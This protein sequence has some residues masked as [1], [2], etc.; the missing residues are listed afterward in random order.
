MKK[1]LALLFSILLL[2]S[3]PVFADSIFDLQIEGISIGDSL[4][5]YMSE[6]EIINSKKIIYDDDEFYDLIAKPKILEIYDYLVFGVK[7]EDNRFLIYSINALLVYDNDIKS[8]LNKK[9]EI[10]SNIEEIFSEFTTVKEYQRPHDEDKTGKSIFYST[11]FNFKSGANVRVM[12]LDLT[13]EF[14]KGPDHLRVIIN[15][16]EYTKWLNS[17][18]YN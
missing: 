8:C 1:L 13:Y 17:V 4:L 14:N 3:P 6:R 5:D 2:S 7:K 15:S 9:K 11:D 10:V 12:C 18:A 16:K